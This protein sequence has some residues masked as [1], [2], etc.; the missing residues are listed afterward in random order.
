VHADLKALREMGVV[1]ALDDFG[2]GYS[3][4]SYLDR[5]PIDILKIDRSFIRDIESDCKKFGLTK[6][7]V[8]IAEALQLELIAE[9]VEREAQATILKE[10]GCGVL[11]GF[12]YGRP[13]PQSEFTRRLRDADLAHATRWLRNSA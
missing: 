10:L 3:A 13:E 8:S 4:M 6:A 5:F 7:I 9:G 2:T 1:I 12:L 11:Q